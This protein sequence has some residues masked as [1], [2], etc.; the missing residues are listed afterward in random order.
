MEVYIG[1]FDIRV[2]TPL[3]HMNTSVPSRFPPSTDSRIP[4]HISTQVD[5]FLS[6]T[7]LSSTLTPSF[8]PSESSSQTPISF[9]YSLRQYSSSQSDKSSSSI[10]SSC[11]SPASPL[12]SPE[13]SSISRSSSSSIPS[14]SS[15]YSCSSS[16]SSSSYSTDDYNVTLARKR[17]HGE[18]FFGR[19]KRTWVRLSGTY[20][21]L[22]EHLPS[23][24]QNACYLTNLSILHK[25][26][27]DSDGHFFSP[28][29]IA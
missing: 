27:D 28:H 11:S 9:S 18:W 14:S 29:T 15:C 23:D 7:P 5:D 20:S 25:N 24:L 17:I 6:Q 26:L 13:L 22:R 8:F 3:K 1:Q 16:S 21:S 2:I 12:F 10:S 4:G 19:I